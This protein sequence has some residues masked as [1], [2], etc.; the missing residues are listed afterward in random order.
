MRL[1]FTEVPKMYVSCLRSYFLSL[2]RGE[3]K[4]KPTD[5]EHITDF[6]IMN[7]PYF[8]EELAMDAIK[9]LITLDSAIAVEIILNCSTK[10][11]KLQ[12]NIHKLSLKINKALG[13]I[14]SKRLQRR[15]KIESK[16][17]YSCKSCRSRYR[18]SFI[19]KLTCPLCK[20]DLC[21]PT[22]QKFI[23][24]LNDKIQ[25]LKKQKKALK[26]LLDSQSVPKKAKTKWIIG[27]YKND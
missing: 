16:P 25:D 24:N 17:F 19:D 22:E 13:D 4:N 14:V 1:D 20:S 2:Q 10:V 18:T 3:V 23:A 11:K 21:T 9:S 27:G 5:W 15:K 6:V 8:S 7:K 12:N 26:Y